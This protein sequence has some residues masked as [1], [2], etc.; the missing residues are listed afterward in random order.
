[1]RPLPWERGARVGAPVGDSS[2]SSGGATSL[3]SS[4]GSASSPETIIGESTPDATTA[5]IPVT[6]RGRARWS[7]PTRLDA[8]SERRP[9]A[10]ATPIS[11]CR[12][13]SERRFR[14]LPVGTPANQTSRVL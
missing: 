11:G 13:K 2:E 3:G 8:S 6:R 1:M 5:I 9:G 14:R 4:R 12:K 7:T 10:T